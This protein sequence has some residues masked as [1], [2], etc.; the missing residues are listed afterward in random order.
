VKRALGGRLKYVSY[1]GAAMPPRLMRLFELAGV[2][3][4]GSY[5]STECGGV[6]LSGL[7]ENRPGNLGKPFPNVEVRI[8]E[9]NEILVRGPTVTPGYF[10]NPQATLQALDA[11]GWFHTGDLGV[12]ERDGSLRMIGRKNDLFY[13]IDGSNI[14]PGQIELVLENDPFIRQAVLLGDCRPFIA[15]LLVPDS[16]NIRAGTAFSDGE[17]GAADIER[18]LWPRVEQINE[19]LDEH[20]KIRRI[21][22]LEKEFPDSVR[23]ITPLQK[24]KI[25]RK[26]LEE[27]Y[28]RVI[29]EIYGERVT[30]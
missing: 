14:F 23:T 28:A 10:K 13:C 24:V 12:L 8:A 29:A 17:L 1:A 18:V 3:L 20:E 25:D 7:G 22:V 15:A 2:P 30:S 26:K 19:T 5:G 4:L 16:A 11:E 27:V 6:T 9:D 21:V